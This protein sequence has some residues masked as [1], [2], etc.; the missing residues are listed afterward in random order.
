MKRKFMINSNPRRSLTEQ[1][2]AERDRREIE[3]INRNA[4]RLNAEA[5][6]AL[7]YQAPI[8]EYTE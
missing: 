4:D 1:E 6:D 5:E 8:D 2:R 3:I 7:E